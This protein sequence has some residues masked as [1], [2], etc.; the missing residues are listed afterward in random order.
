MQLQ[1]LALAASNFIHHGARA[2]LVAVSLRDFTNA[3][4]EEIFHTFK[5]TPPNPPGKHKSKLFRNCP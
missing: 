2:R 3:A 5:I 4:N 1:D